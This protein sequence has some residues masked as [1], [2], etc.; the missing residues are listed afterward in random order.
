MTLISPFK[1]PKSL[2]FLRPLPV[3]NVVLIT[4]AKIPLYWAG[5]HDRP[6]DGLRPSADEDLAIGLAHMEEHTWGWAVAQHPALR[7]SG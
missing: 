1:C 7:A 6:L 3:L 5:P 2:C 4:E